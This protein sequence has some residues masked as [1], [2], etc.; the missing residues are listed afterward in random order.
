MNNLKEKFEQNT[1]V[2]TNLDLETKESIF[3]SKVYYVSSDKDNTVL[4]AINPQIYE[5]YILWDDGDKERIF[6][7]AS[8]YKIEDILILSS[9][10]ATYFLQ[11]MTFA[12]YNSVIKSELINPPAT[13]NSQEELEEY[14]TEHFQ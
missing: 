7:L 4:I 11:P 12:I 14:F 5:R 1:V 8:A 9:D 3:S 2:P 10:D 13:I 6:P